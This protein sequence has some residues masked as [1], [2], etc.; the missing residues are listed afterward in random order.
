MQ[1]IHLYD[2]FVISVTRCKRNLIG[3]NGN[4]WYFPLS[5]Y[6]LM[7]WFYINAWSF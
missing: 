7:K 1:L 2:I 3:G 6:T 4:Y 5:L